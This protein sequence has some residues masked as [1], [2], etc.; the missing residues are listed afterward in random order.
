MIND[1][2]NTKLIYVNGN[3]IPIWTYGNEL[4]PMIVFIHGHFRGFSEYI[5]DLPIRYLMKDYFIVAFDMP[6]YST[7]KFI[8]L[9][10]INFVEKVVKSL[11]KR[12]YVIFG[13]SLGGVVALKYASKYPENIK[14]LIIS[15]T[16]YYF[17]IKKIIFLLS[18][19]PFLDISKAVNEFKFLTKDNLS[20]I[21][22]PVL[23]LYS[24]NDK[25]ANLR[26]GERFNKYINNSK[27]FKIENL[28]HKW[29][30]HEINKSGFLNAINLFFKN[31]NF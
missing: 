12:P 15:G 17:G 29:L 9:D 1:P 16:P 6:G 22:I 19:F 2:R 31:I 26:M 14:G 10:K 24:S 18:F 25:H 21:N 4:N 27:L 3:E 20:K 11:N 23:L 13:N 28:N 8:K 5:G 7:S 30:L